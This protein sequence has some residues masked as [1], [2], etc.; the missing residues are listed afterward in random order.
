MS[1]AA[2]VKSCCVTRCPNTSA[3]PNVKFFAFPDARYKSYHRKRWVQTIRRRNNSKWWTPEPHSVVCSEH[4]VS[5]RPSRTCKNRDYVPSVFVSHSSKTN[6]DFEVRSV[7][8]KQFA[9]AYVAQAALLDPPTRDNLRTARRRAAYARL[10]R[11]LHIPERMA[12]HWEGRLREYYA[13]QLYALPQRG[14]RWL[15]A[16]HARLTRRPASEDAGDS[17]A[18]SGAATG[19]TG[20]TVADKQDTDKTEGT[21]VSGTPRADSDV[22]TVDAHTWWRRVWAGGLVAAL[23]A[24]AQ[25]RGALCST[26]LYT[27]VRRELR[28]RVPL[29]DLHELWVS[30]QRAALEQVRLAGRA[31]DVVAVPPEAARVAELVLLH[32]DV[33]AQRLLDDES[34]SLHEEAAA[35]HALWRLVQRHALEDAAE[36]LRLAR[37][38]SRLHR[39]YCASGRSA[40]LVVLQRRWH[41]LKL[42]ARRRLAAHWRR[43]LPAP[44]P[45]PA[46]LPPL[47]APIHLAILK[48]Y[49]H[50]ATEAQVSWRELVTERRVVRQP[51]PEQLLSDDSADETDRELSPDSHAV[52]PASDADTSAIS[53]DTPAIFADTPV[54][55][56]DT[57]AISADVSATSADMSAISAVAPA[58]S[59]DMS[60]ISAVAPT[61]SADTPAISA[62]TPAISEDTPAVSADTLV[63]S[64]DTPD[65]SVDALKIINSTRADIQASPPEPPDI[66]PDLLVPLNTAAASTQSA[67]EPALLVP[68]HIGAAPKREEWDTDAE[69]NLVID[70]SCSKQLSPAKPLRRDETSDTIAVLR[71]IDPSAVTA[72]IVFDSDDDSEPSVQGARVESPLPRTRRGESISSRLFFDDD[73]VTPADD[74][75][76]EP[77]EQKVPVNTPAI[78]PKLLL[79]ARV[80][81]VRLEDAPRRHREAPPPAPLKREAPPL[82]PL[83]RLEPRETP[84][85][86][87]K[88]EAAPLP[89]FVRI[90]PRKR[91]RS[92]AAASVQWDEQAGGPPADA[93]EA[94]LRRV[95]LRDIEQ[96]RRRN[97]LLLTAQVKPIPATTAAPAA[98]EPADHSADDDLTGSALV[99]PNALELSDALSRLAAAASTH[100]L[101]DTS[102]CCAARRHRA[103]NDTRRRIGLPPIDLHKHAGA[104]CSCCCAHTR[105]SGGALLRQLAA[106]HAHVARVTRQTQTEPINKKKSKNISS[107]DTLATDKDPKTAKP[108][109]I[110]IPKDQSKSVPTSKLR[111]ILMSNKKSVADDM[112][113]STPGSKWNL[114]PDDQTSTP[115]SKSKSAPRSV[116]KSTP[117]DKTESTPPA[118]K[119]KSTPPASKSKSASGSVSKPTPDDKTP[120]STS[121]SAPGSVLK[122]TPDEKTKPTPASKSKSASR[123]K[124]KSTPGSNSMCPASAMG[125]S[126]G[127]SAAF[128]S[129]YSEWLRQKSVNTQ[130]FNFPPPPADTSRRRRK[131]PPPPVLAPAPA[132]APAPT[133]APAPA[134]PTLVVSPLSDARG[135]RVAQ[136][137]S[138]RPLSILEEYARSLPATP[139]PPTTMLSAGS[140][141][142]VALPVE[143]LGSLARAVRAARGPGGGAA[144]RPRLLSLAHAVPSADVIEIPDDDCPE[145]A[146]CLAPGSEACEPAMFADP[147]AMP[148][149]LQQLSR[150]A[151]DDS[152][153]L[154]VHK[155]CA[156]V[157]A[158]RRVRCGAALLRADAARLPRVLRAGGRTLLLACEAELPAAQPT[159]WTLDEFAVTQRVELDD[160]RADR[161]PEHRV[162][163]HQHQFQ[164]V[165]AVC[166]GAGLR[167]A[168]AGGGRVFALDVLRAR[169]HELA[170]TP[171]TRAGRSLYRAAP[172]HAMPG[173]DLYGLEFELDAD[174]D[175]CGAQ[176]TAQPAAAADDVTTGPAP[177]NV[178]TLSLVNATPTEHTAKLTSVLA[179][180][181]SH[182]NTVLAAGTSHDMATVTKLE[183]TCDQASASAA[184][185]SQDVPPTLVAVKSQDTTEDVAE[186]HALS[187]SH[188]TTTV[189]P[190]EASNELTNV[191]ALVTTDDVTP[192]LTVAPQ[193]STA[194]VLIT[195]N[196]QAS[197]SVLVTS[198]DMADDV[199]PSLATV[200]SLGTASGMLSASAAETPHETTDDVT[201]RMVAVKS[202]QT[203]N[204]VTNTHDTT[205]DVTAADTHTTTEN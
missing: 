31:G 42:Q 127:A 57:P 15:R 100:R 106:L 107:S 116:S 182:D 174:D 186:V 56:A 51:L 113:K 66:K 157:V 71:S 194:P 148:D 23:A 84:L 149:F 87:H 13:A 8:M 10:A 36:P 44:A 122:S 39:D 52:T 137:I 147:R 198:Q 55:S 29:P 123:R 53:A 171:S 170:L 48:R 177:G 62:D 82:A 34:V 183:P 73:D 124:S 50:V 70:E 59:A 129:A 37:R 3:T 189:T 86:P 172:R 24:A 154:Y 144:R 134:A 38:W 128:D 145:P 60:A 7:S 143:A 121:K 115:A 89:A 26:A 158:A 120:A 61:I 97:Q 98:D 175:T 196:D 2:A 22:C 75:T 191:V 17:A 179:P 111:A 43:P 173:D 90:A 205:G 105:D 131:K 69:D 164:V 91:P 119:S 152:E 110:S 47:P 161:V 46:S 126:P 45:L 167:Q 32:T 19:S 118:S 201:P 49:P 162:C 168:V 1:E 204:D 4:F 30:V 83:V 160:D 135:R 112:S 193:V 99:L 133:P 63:T 156:R 21:A 94:A 85:V 192:T 202:L 5:G 79:E 77:L 190:M 165:T 114:T 72:E 96:V 20:A 101:I 188:D 108:K 146:G 163:Q 178:A 140:T 93:R 12:R 76:T 68:S 33:A 197:D 185:T 54:I 159:Y 181:T 9:L 35:L 40:S 203:S 187:T 41:E 155:R 103:V 176:Y 25:A 92:R 109:P 142:L 102:Y 199:T 64:A 6:G 81:L 141:V 104:A 65:I 95:L 153:Q 74:V 151:D 58:I 132:P 28:R 16:V 125:V 11:Q 78:D 80:C 27:L 88:R 150:A 184:V 18:D 130:Y 138:Q 139:P 67:S 14:P 166:D 117:D 169:R 136:P 200:T 195:T 180:V